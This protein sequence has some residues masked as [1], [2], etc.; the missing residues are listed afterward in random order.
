MFQA[1]LPVKKKA[2]LELGLYIHI[3]IGNLYQP[4]LSL[5]GR[6]KLHLNNISSTF[7]HTFEPKRA[8][9]TCPTKYIGSSRNPNQRFL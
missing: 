5:K 8:S 6:H 7:E 2:L 3:G 1:P 9:H 4:I